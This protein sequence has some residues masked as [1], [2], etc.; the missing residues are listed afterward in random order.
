MENITIC[1]A[2]VH[3]LAQ[4]DRSLWPAKQDNWVT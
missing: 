1:Q 4:L 2:F 3:I